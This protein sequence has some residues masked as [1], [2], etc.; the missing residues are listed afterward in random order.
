MHLPF[1]KEKKNIFDKMIAFLDFEILQVLAN[2]LK[3]KFVESTLK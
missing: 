3:K 1:G 2:T